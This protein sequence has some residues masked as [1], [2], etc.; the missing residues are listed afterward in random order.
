[1]PEWTR[2][3]ETW[4]L[5]GFVGMAVFGACLANTGDG[6]GQIREEFKWIWSVCGAFCL[7]LTQGVRTLEKKH[8]GD[9]KALDTGV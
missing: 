4:W 2:S 9:E 7:A 8:A 3:L 5:V 6:P 1:M